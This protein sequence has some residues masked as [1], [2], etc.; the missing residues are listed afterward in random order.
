MHVVAVTRWGTPF[1]QALPELAARL[2]M[3]AYDLRLR[4]GGGLPVVFVRVAEASEAAEH[5]TFLRARGHGAVACDGRSIPGPE[6]QLVPAD[7]EPTAT[8]MRGKCT[9]GRP[10]ELRYADIFAMIHASCVTSAE[11]TVTTQQKQFAPGRAILSGGMVL[12]KTVD[13]VDKTVEQEQERTIYVFC[14]SQPFVTVWRELTLSY[15]GLGDSLRPTAVQNFQT[16]SNGLRKLTPQAFHD[17][18]LLTNKRSADVPAFAA[19][20]KDPGV[21]V[22]N[23]SELDLAAFL[24]VRGHI[25]GQL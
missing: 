11:R 5:L 22:S 23:A 8:A 16:L 10:F 2:G 9:Q 3:V 7:F 20:A 6:H 18:R 1:D 25:E 15:Q 12:R 17:E 19:G 21:D 4:L 24:L 14:R 13:R